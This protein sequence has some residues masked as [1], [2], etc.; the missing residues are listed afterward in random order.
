ML[1]LKKQLERKYY[2]T[3]MKTSS[4]SNKYERKS[5]KNDVETTD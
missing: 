2:L 4:V 1:A 3:T 5:C